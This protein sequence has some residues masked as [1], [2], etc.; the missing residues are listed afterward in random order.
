MGGR[1]NASW[2]SWLELDSAASSDDGL[3]DSE[4]EGAG[5]VS[6]S[7]EM[8]TLVLGDCSAEEEDPADD[9]VA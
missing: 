9:E 6:P 8:W 2:L 5:G 4:A 1:A 7:W 3:R